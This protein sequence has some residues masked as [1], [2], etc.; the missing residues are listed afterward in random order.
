MTEHLS[1]RAIETQELEQTCPKGKGAL[2][3]N[4]PIELFTTKRNTQKNKHGNK[5]ADEGTP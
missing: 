1:E 2:R 3:K 5:K 4:K